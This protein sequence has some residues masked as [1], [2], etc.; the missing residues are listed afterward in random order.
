ME[1][2][3]DYYT[4]TPTSSV[5]GSPSSSISAPLR[6][7]LDDEVG[8]PGWGTLGQRVALFAKRPYS[9]KRQGSLMAKGGG[10]G[11]IGT[12]RTPLLK[13]SIHF[14]LSGDSS[15]RQLYREGGGDEEE[16]RARLIDRTF[17][18][19]PTRLLNHHVST[20]AV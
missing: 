15:V 6:T 3:Q 4:F 19:W 2:L 11:G 7:R 20:S 10:Y 8:R 5:S 17:G 18:S 14:L 9:R 16:D 1:N 12:E 13:P